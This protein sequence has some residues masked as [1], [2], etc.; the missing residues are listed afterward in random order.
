M[1]FCPTQK[2]SL[3]RTFWLLR[4]GQPARLSAS[5]SLWGAEKPSNVS[6]TERFGLLSTALQCG[7]KGCVCVHCCCILVSWEVNPF[8]YHWQPSQGRR[9]KALV[10]RVRA[11]EDQRVS[12]PVNTGERVPTLHISY[13][14]SEALWS[15]QVRQQNDLPGWWRHQHLHR[16][17][18]KF[19]KKAVEHSQ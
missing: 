9:L 15:Q 18:T 1:N 7:L 8:S 5:S 11:K 4:R 2:A 19:F 3:W 12:K 17:C 16:L 6:P 10:S 14:G 13:Y